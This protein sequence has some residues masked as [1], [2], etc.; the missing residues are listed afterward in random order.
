MKHD[1]YLRKINSNEE[2]EPGLLSELEVDIPPGMHDRI[3]DS[4]KIENKRRSKFAKYKIFAPVA[5]AAIVI[6]VSIGSFSGLLNDGN[7]KK[8]NF[9]AKNSTSSQSNKVTS[10]EKNTNNTLNK[11]TDTKTASAAAAYGQV[12]S[13]SNTADAKK[14]AAQKNTTGSTNKN[15]VSPS[16]KY[17]NSIDEN[18]VVNGSTIE[19]VVIDTGTSGLIASTSVADYEL[20][21]YKDEVDIL[22]FINQKC[23]FVD[24]YNNYYKIRNEDFEILSDMVSKRT[25]GC[26]LIETNKEN[27]SRK[28]DYLLLKLIVK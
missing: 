12:Q 23:E 16:T 8:N 5:A 26:K 3:M 10:G 27:S 14:S 19:D 15:T 11:Q 7:E 28:S 21:I 2:I 18:T 20:T 25:D 17:Q 6:A 9:T 1:E 4:I 24:K 13:K 22:S